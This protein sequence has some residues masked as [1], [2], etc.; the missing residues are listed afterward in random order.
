MA[1][2]ESATWLA[3]R[4][5]PEAKEQVEVLASTSK[6]QGSVI[7]GFDLMLGNQ[8]ECHW[9]Y[10]AYYGAGCDPTDRGW[11]VHGGCTPTQAK[12]RAQIAKFKTWFN[13]LHA[14]NGGITE[15]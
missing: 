1:Q 7:C 13:N 5:A 10:F 14:Q 4:L 11:A 15:L 9:F 3:Q 6:A 8:R 2:N 12:S